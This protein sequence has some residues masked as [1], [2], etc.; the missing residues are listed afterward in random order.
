M[1]GDATV[2]SEHGDAAALVMRL[3]PARSRKPSG[4]LLSRSVL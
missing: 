4:G 2:A 3:K 1:S